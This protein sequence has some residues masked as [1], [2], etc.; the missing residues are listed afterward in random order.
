MWMLARLSFGGEGSEG[1][2]AGGQ[3][4]RRWFGGGEVIGLGK[5]YIFLI[6]F[7]DR[8]MLKLQFNSGKVY[9]FSYSILKKGDKN[10]LITLALVGLVL[11]FWELAKD[12]IEEDQEND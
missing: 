6:N 3:K 11:L 9:R 8:S 7:R 4:R 1:Q 5:Y 10:M 2:Q 12:V